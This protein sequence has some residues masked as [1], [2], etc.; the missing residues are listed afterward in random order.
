MR[1]SLLRFINGFILVVFTLL[2][3]SGVYGLFWYMPGWVFELHRL[4]GWALL[5]ALPW[6]TAI[7][8]R[9]LRR[10]LKADFDRGVLILVSTLLGAATLLVVAL[11]LA[12]SWRLGPQELWLRQT[13]ISWHWLLALGLVAPFGLIAWR[14]WPRPR[15]ADSLSRRA[16]LKT[17]GL[18][19]LS[20]A[21]WWAAEAIAGKRAA[22]VSPRRITGSRLDGTYS[23]NRFP[24]THTIAAT[25]KQVDVTHWRLSLEGAVATPRAFTYMELLELPSGE[26]DAILDCTLGWYTQQVWRGLA[27][28]ELLAA[29]GVSSNAFAVKLESVT[30]FAQI[31]PLVEAEGVLLATHVGGETLEHLHGFSLRAVVS[32]WRGWFWV[33]WLSRIEILAV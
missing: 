19:L 24:V 11:G 4:T 12:W 9:S 20:I 30:G 23:G 25:E 22:L 8:F 14:R 2:T 32:S 17:L 10:G 28:R 16:V 15:R 3:L 26:L 33:K 18:G 29:Q 1:F 27:L 13:A 6:K 31:L 5:A 7:S 21:G